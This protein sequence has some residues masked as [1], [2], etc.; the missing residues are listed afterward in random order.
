MTI[1]RTARAARAI[2]LRRAD[3]STPPIAHRFATPR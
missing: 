3:F 2:S 1:F